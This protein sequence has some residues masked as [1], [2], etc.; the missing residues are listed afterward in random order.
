ME[1]TVDEWIVYFIS[2]PQRRKDALRFLEKLFQKCDKLCTMGGEALDQKIWRMDKESENWDPIGRRFVKWFIAQI[3]INPNKFRI[4]E[5]SDLKILPAD[6]EQETP[7][8]DLYLVKAAMN[9]ADKLILTTDSKLKE[10]LSSKQ[11][12][13]IL[14][15]NEFLPQYDCH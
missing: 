11:E 2:D 13:I 14:L 7:P 8:D 9:T 15:V 4:L 3:R 1:I 5:G 10:R 12:L 6:L